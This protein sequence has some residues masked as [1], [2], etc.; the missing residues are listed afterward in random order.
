MVKTPRPA[1]LA[2]SV[3]HASSPSQGLLLP[4]AESQDF[5]LT[6]VEV[7]EGREAHCCLGDSGTLLP[8]FYCSEQRY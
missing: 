3:S 1:L 4:D 8:G 2:A 7:A 6:Q 5:G